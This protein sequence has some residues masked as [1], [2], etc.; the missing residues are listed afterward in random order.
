MY[1]V[2]QKSPHPCLTFHMDS[3]MHAL[4]H[5]TQH[6]HTASDTVVTYHLELSQCLTAPSMHIQSVTVLLPSTLKFH[7]VRKRT[8]H[9][10]PLAI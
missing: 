7:H 6:A 5:G 4:C 9:T 10:D 1:R 8:A 2:A 3:Y